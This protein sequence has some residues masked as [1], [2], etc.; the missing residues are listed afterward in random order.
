[1]WPQAVPQEPSGDQS[2][3]NHPNLALNEERKTEAGR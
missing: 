1:M 3:A 2:Q